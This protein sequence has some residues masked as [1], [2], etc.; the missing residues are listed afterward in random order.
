MRLN[1]TL[2]QHCVH[3]LDA[4]FQIDVSW[5]SLLHFFISRFQLGMVLDL[6]NLSFISCVCILVTLQHRRQAEARGEP[7]GRVEALKAVRSEAQPAQT[8]THVPIRSDRGVLGEATQLLLQ[9]IS[10]KFIC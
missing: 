3:S 8:K 10:L 2:L 1:I 4:I 6:F 5:L 9:L 7:L